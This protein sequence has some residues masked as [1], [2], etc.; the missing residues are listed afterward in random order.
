MLETPKDQMCTATGSHIAHF[1][2]LNLL[3]FILGGI[4]GAGDPCVLQVRRSFCLELQ[5]A[6]CCALR[7]SLYIQHE[8]KYIVHI[9]GM[10]TYASMKM[11]TSCMYDACQCVCALKW[12]HNAYK[13]RINLCEQEKQHLMH[14]RCM[15]YNSD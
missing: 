9:R 11:K 7:S 12:M 5:A 8:H 6:G 14:V 4:V 10:T 13:I 2:D 3:F 15:L 1:T